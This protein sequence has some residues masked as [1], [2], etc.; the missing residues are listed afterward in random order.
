MKRWPGNA[1]SELTTFGSLSRSQLMSRVRSFGNR[2]TELAVIALLRKAK[3]KGWRRHL[4][5]A[6]K[7]DFCWPRGR[8]ALFVDG[9]FWHGHERCGKNIRPRSNAQLWAAKIERNRKH[10][11]KI[12]SYLRTKGWAVVRV[13]ECRLTKAPEMF[14]KR[15]AAKLD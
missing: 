9:C 14:L 13:W 6:G 7:P 2:T 11:R 12:S 15:L 5:I 10:D 3:L 4:S 1:R 8:V